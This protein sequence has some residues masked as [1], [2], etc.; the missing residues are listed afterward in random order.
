ME[1]ITTDEEVLKKMM[2]NDKLV[3]LWCR[4]LK[5]QF[6]IREICYEPD[7]YEEDYVEKITFYM[8]L[9]RF[10][11]WLDGWRGFERRM[12]GCYSA[13]RVYDLHHLFYQVR[14][15]IRYRGSIPF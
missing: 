9:C 4:C 1:E 13:R 7:Y 12:C 5:N 15:L 11:A 10:T 3:A 8:Y 14:Y 2:K 6:V